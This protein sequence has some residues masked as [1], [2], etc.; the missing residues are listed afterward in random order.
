MEER[1]GTSKPKGVVKTHIF[2]RKENRRR[3]SENNR[4][5]NFDGV[6][7]KC[8]EEWNALDHAGRK[9]YIDFNA[10]DKKRHTK[11]TVAYLNNKDENEDDEG[12]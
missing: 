4:H 12:A 7:K 3:I 5:L 1:K 6:V 11:E 2:F 9:K 10:E 8:Q